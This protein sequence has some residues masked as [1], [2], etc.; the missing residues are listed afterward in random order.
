MNVSRREGMIVLGKSEDRLPEHGGHLLWAARRYGKSPGD[1]IDFSANINPLG[2]PDVVI[3]T[4]RTSLDDIIHYPDP[5]GIT[6]RQAV[7][8]RWQIPADAVRPLNG[9]AEGFILLLQWWRP[10]RVVIPGP[11]FAGYGR[12][13]RA[14]GVDPFHVPFV[15][16]RQHRRFALDVTA[17]KK[18][19]RFGK[20]DVVMLANPNNPTG[21]LVEEDTL[22]E[23]LYVI[24]QRGA[25]LLLDEA[26]LDFVPDEAQRSL[27]RKAACT[28]RL[29][30]VRSLTKMYALPGLRLGFVVGTSSLLNRLDRMR[31]PW[32]VNNL[33]LA[34]GVAALQA[35]N[36]HVSRTVHFVQTERRWLIRELSRLSRVT[37]WD[38]VA[39]FLLLQFHPPWPDATQLVQRL[40]EQGILVRTGANFVGLGSSYVRIAVRTRSDNERLLTALRHISASGAGRWPDDGTTADGD[41][42]VFHSPRIDAGK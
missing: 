42:P 28:D 7:A 20:G 10:G 34:A 14:V 16:R 11:A 1:F 12:A 32:P 30:V 3:E 31:Q 2:P 22:Q 8:R 24:G 5:D 27:C 18:A 26:F 35:G 17:V 9:A 4:L 41:A 6:F 29:V 21:H 39:N 25:F 23:L 19:L 33:A 40:A 15:A 38:G 37:V 13:A 36:D